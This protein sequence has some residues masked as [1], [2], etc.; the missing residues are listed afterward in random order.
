MAAGDRHVRDL[1]DLPLV[2]TA[3]EA[4]AALRLSRG[5]VYQAL[6][7]GTLRSCRVGRAV[8]IPRAAI[9]ELLGVPD[10]PAEQEPAR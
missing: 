1:A 8:R 2:C 3:A 7:D 10:P 9:A 6:R 4:A 5:L